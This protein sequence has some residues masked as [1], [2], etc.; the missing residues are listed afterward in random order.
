MHSKIKKFINNYHKDENYIFWP[1]LA[2]AH[3]SK[4]TQKNPNQLNI[5]LL[6]K[7]CNPP[8][9]PKLR[10]IEKYWAYLKKKIYSN[11]KSF[12]NFNQIKL[13]AYMF[14]ILSYVK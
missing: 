11:G 3:Y 4:Y 9:C 10:P 5:K 8:N 7:Q 13:Q 1:D 6:P 2:T 14:F 12:K